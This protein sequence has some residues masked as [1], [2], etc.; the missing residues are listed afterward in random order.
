MSLGPVKGLTA[1]EAEIA[2]LMIEGLDYDEVILGEAVRRTG[3]SR[4]CRRRGRSATNLGRRATSLPIAASSTS[5]GRLF[6]ERRESEQ[7]RNLATAIEIRDNEGAATKTVRLK[8]AAFI[9]GNEKPGVTVN[10]NTQTNVAAITPGY[11]IRL[12]AKADQGALAQAAL[13]T[14]HGE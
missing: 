8:A 5:C 12:P 6:K 3:R 7:A 1:V 9:E 13:A 10:V 2:R 14:D 4:L 11:V